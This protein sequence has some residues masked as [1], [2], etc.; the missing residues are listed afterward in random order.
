MRIMS[1][2]RTPANY[3][4][5]E[6]RL[7]SMLE[8]LLGQDPADVLNR[9]IDREDIRMVE[10]RDGPR[11]AFQPRE[12][13]G[14]ERGR[15]GQH[16]DGDVPPQARVPGTVHLSHAAS[17]YQGDHLVRPESSARVHGHRWILREGINRGGASAAYR[18]RPLSVIPF[19]LR[20]FHDPQQISAQDLRHILI[21]VAPSLQFTCDLRELRSIFHT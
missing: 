18:V 5:N 10:A 2:S 14:I 1:T 4:T 12:A 21:R 7:D 20:L 3:A 13:L 8:D 16:L 15:G 6:T 17:A 11:L 9:H 19:E